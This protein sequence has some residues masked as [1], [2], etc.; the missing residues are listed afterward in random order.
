MIT[1]YGLATLN[2]LINGT[3]L[4]CVLM[5]ALSIWRGRIET[6]KRW[7]L[8]A[9]GLSIAFLASYISRMVLFGDTRFQGTGGVRYAYFFL[10]ISHVGLALLIAPFVIYTVVLGVKDQRERHRRIAPKVLPFWLYVLATGVLVYL[11]LHHWP[12]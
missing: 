3:A 12:V 11:A 2:A 6:H 10:L 8:T 9:F 5:G 4:V 1:N 7:M